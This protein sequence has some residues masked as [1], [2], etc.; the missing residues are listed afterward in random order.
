M[1]KYYIMWSDIHEFGLL[2][3]FFSY[4]IFVM[5]NKY[6][7]MWSDINELPSTTKQYTIM[8]ISYSFCIITTACL[9]LQQMC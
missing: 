6:Y 9:L 4:I 2:V 5:M 3:Y 7:I 8:F 1:N